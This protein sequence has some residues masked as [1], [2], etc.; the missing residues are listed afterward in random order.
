LKFVQ[1]IFSSG[2]LLS[3]WKLS[4][5]KMFQAKYRQNLRYVA[6][7]TEL[8]VHFSRK[9]GVQS[10]FLLPNQLTIVINCGDLLFIKLRVTHW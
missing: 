6:K 2:K 3:L 1:S 7:V 5:I 8:F 9:T 4:E 10:Y